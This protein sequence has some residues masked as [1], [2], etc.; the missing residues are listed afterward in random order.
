VKPSP[1]RA[2]PH[3]AESWL[4]L[5]DLDTLPAVDDMVRAWSD[6]EGRVHPAESKPSPARAE[7]HD[8]GAWLPVPADFDGLPSVEELLTVEPA[9]LPV[10][11]APPPSPPEV[12]APAGR[13]R[14]WPRPGVRT[15]AVLV[16]A[17]LTL[18]GIAYLVP[19]LFDRG[20]SVDVRVDGR[21]VSA[22]TGVATVGAFLR[23]AHVRV[24]PHDRVVP[25]PKAKISDG[26]HVIVARGFAITVDLDGNQQT[27]WTTYHSPVDFMDK[28]LRP[29]DDVVVRANPSRLDQGSLVVLRTKHEGTLVIDGQV[30]PF[31]APADDIDELL[32][33]YSVQLR[34]SDFVAVNGQSASLDTPLVAGA[35]YTVMRFG[36]GTEQRQ[37][38]YTV[39]A[40][41]LPDPTSAVGVNRTVAGKQGTETVTEVVTRLNGFVTGRTTVSKVPVVAAVPTIHYYGTRADPM[42]DRIAA[43]ETGGNWG[44]VG[45][46]FSGGLGFYN[47]T[48][49]AYGGR[50]YAANAGLAT[51]EQ[52]ILVAMEIQRKV[53][54]GGWG[55]AHKLGYAK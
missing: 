25:G 41:T 3:D 6:A 15:V 48:W 54:L 18:G 28:G 17:A 4:P 51:R 16:L 52:Q 45:P 53:G 30:V 26:L 44:F 11:S 23:E 12:A 47:G 5:P 50:K 24:G 31:N 20:A 21:V 36:E 2:E 13:S 49:D 42:W 9:P 19:R 40:V 37:E 10:S 27:V 35:T 38:S 1:A 55:C 46:S 8:P 43:C 22:R 32:H 14:R 33:Q 34:P 7:P 39:G 29:G